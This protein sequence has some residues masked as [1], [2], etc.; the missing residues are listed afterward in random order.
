MLKFNIYIINLS[1]ILVLFACAGN[2]ETRGY[3]PNENKIEKIKSGKTTKED[4]VRDIG[5]PSSVNAFDKNIWVYVETKF[6]TNPIFDPKEIESKVL[7]ISFSEKDI[8]NSV[9]NYSVTDGADKEFSK[10]TTQTYGHSIN[11]V[12]QIIG[13]V[14]KFNKQPQ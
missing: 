8:V 7:E 13:N 3:F 12:Q 2:I 10:E 14:G 9:K 6:E 4:V 5:Y 11:A 1:L